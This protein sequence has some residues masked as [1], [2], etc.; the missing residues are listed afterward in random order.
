MAGE[1]GEVREDF[2]LRM[3]ARRGR[4]GCGVLQ[5]GSFDRN[6]CGS[7]NVTGSPTLALVSCERKIQARCEIQ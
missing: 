6:R 3:G 4:L 7:P 5:A 1:G 2:T